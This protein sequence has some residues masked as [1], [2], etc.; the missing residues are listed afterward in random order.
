MDLYFDCFSGISGDMTLGAFVDLGVPV[1]YLVHE[2]ARLPLEGFDITTEGVSRHGIQAT[3]LFVHETGKTHP[4]DYRTIRNRV[5]SSPLSDYVK[6]LSLSMFEKIA[7][8]ESRIHGC[9]KD[10]VHFHEVGGID[11]LVDMVGTAL[12]MEYMDVRSVHASPLP[13][14]SGFTACAHGVIPVPAPATAEILKGVPVYGTDTRMELVTPTGAAIIKTLCGSFGPLPA[15]TVNRSA[16]GSGKRHRDDRPNLLRIIAG[17][18]NDT[19]PP[20][21]EGGVIVL[22][23]TI[24][25]M[26]PELYGFVMERLF[27]DGALDVTLQP[28]FMKKNRPGTVLTVLCRSEGRDILTR[29]ILTET[30][31]TGVRYYPVRR[32]VLHR[33]AASVTT[34][35]GDVQVKVITRPDGSVH[36]TP[37]YESCKALARERNIP[38]YRIYEEVIRSS[39]NGDN[40]DDDR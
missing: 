15:M 6:A 36:F 33:K 30:S 11:A 23:S 40:K 37:E 35:F 17:T 2:L 22:E 8:A 25:D 19:A 38:L 34:R 12:C 16:Y 21:D 26:N 13:L 29:R 9:P 5:E 4:M 10:R 20:A 32:T 27:E 24:D 31:S 14:G 28:V 3:N 1:S 7:A 18:V 39:G